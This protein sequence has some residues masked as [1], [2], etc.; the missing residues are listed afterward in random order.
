MILED[1]KQLFLQTLGLGFF[2]R[3]VLFEVCVYYLE[4]IVGERDREGRDRG[5]EGFAEVS[6]GSAILSGV[7]DGGED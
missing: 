2:V 4:D 6:E 1:S 7:Q 5:V 3:V